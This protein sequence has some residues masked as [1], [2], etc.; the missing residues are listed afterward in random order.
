MAKFTMFF[1]QLKNVCDLEFLKSY[2]VF[3]SMELLIV[4]GT[5]NRKIFRRL[6]P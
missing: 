2:C 6:L 4:Y 3:E 1:S 5:F